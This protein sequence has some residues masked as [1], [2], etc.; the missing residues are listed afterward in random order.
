V[1]PWPETIEEAVAQTAGFAGKTSV[2]VAVERVKRVAQM[3]E[4]QMSKTHRDARYF[5][6][7][8]VPEGQTKAGWK[9]KSQ[10]ADNAKLDNVGLTWSVIL[11]LNGWQLDAVRQTRTF[12]AAHAG[13]WEVG[14]FNNKDALTGKDEAVAGGEEWARRVTKI[15]KPLLHRFKTTHWLGATTLIKR[16]WDLA[17][18]EPQWGLE[19]TKFPDTRGIASGDPE[20]KNPENDEDESVDAEEPNSSD[21]YFAVL[22]FDGD[23]IGKWMSGE[24]TPPFSTQLAEYRD[25]TQTQK[26]GART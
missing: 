9:D 4:S 21:S 19:I 17:Y 11:A 18:L 13:G 16:L 25:G 26:F 1:T 15:G 20:C 24:K 3:A 23:E 5:E 14:T 2:R 7:P 22:A 10:L 6:C 8:R 12:E